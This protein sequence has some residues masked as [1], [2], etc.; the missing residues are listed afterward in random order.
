MNCHNRS[1]YWTHTQSKQQAERQGTASY[2][3]RTAGHTGRRADA[4]LMI[5][6]NKVQLTA[7]N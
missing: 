6:A 3:W 4:R 5:A 1:Q 7:S 2:C